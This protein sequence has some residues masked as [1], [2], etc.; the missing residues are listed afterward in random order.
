MARSTVSVFR[1]WGFAPMGALLVG[2]SLLGS[3]ESKYGLSELFPHQRKKTNS[4][5]ATIS[6]ENFPARNPKTFS[7]QNCLIRV[8]R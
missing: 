1:N 8:I 7:R 3:M 4:K 6:K 2:V 5:A